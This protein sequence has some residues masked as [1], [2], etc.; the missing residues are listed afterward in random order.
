[1]KNITCNCKFVF[2]EVTQELKCNCGTVKISNLKNLNTI[3]SVSDIEKFYNL[4]FKGR[5]DSI[6]STVKFIDLISFVSAL[7]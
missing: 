4:H 6:H 2:N 5:L 3:P 7:K 1:M